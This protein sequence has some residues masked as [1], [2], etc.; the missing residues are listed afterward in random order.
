MRPDKHKKKDFF[1]GDHDYDETIRKD[2][3]IH[4]IKDEDVLDEL[5]SKGL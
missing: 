1:K 2:R 5:P 4:H 3:K